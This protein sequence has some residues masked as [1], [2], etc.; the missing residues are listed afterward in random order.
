MKTELAPFA[1][2]ID[3]VLQC[4]RERCTLLLRCGKQRPCPNRALLAPKRALTERYLKRRWGQASWWRCRGAPCGL[5]WSVSAVPAR[6]GCIICREIGDESKAWARSSLAPCGC[7]PIGGGQRRT[8]TVPCE[9]LSG[10]LLHQ[11][12][13]REARGISR[14]GL[15]VLRLSPHR[16]CNPKGK[17]LSRCRGAGLRLGTGTGVGLG[18]GVG[19]GVAPRLGKHVKPSEAYPEVSG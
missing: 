4:R 13:S 9:F 15:W 2:R 6:R 7:R 19:V 5:P 11:Q 18:V 8:G 3:P 1:P 14:S 17:R 12:R 16:R 10:V